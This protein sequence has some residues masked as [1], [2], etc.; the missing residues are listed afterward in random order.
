VLSKDL[1]VVTANQAYYKS[2]AV[3]PE[4]IINKNFFDLQDG[5]WNMPKLR[6]LLEEIIRENSA[7]SDFEVDYEAPGAGRRF[8][9]L[10]AR[11]VAR[12]EQLILLAIEDITAR[13]MAEEERDK[14]DLDRKEALSK[15]KKLAGMLPICA[16]CKKIRNDEGY[17]EQIEAYIRD[18]S[19]VEFTHGICPECA[20]KLYSEIDTKQDKKK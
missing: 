17:W 10:N 18:H 11:R 2:F 16:S 3:T 4:V 14:I 1:R 9:L 7:F 13:R 12:E 15:V 20:D 6:Q 5:L 8:M 19:E